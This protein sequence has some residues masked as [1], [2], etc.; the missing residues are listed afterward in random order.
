M[1]AR[2]R[3]QNIWVPSHAG[4]EGNK[5]ADYLAKDSV[6][7]HRRGFYLQYGPAECMEFINK[8]Q[9]ENGKIYGKIIKRY[10]EVT[11]VTIQ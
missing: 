10:L 7:E 9:N 8:L 5:G 4:F 1:Q 2:E 11:K 6:H 3:N